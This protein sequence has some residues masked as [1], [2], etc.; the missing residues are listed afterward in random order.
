[1]TDTARTILIVA[2]RTASTPALLTRVRAS[3]RG[4]SFMV[5][6]PPEAADAV[7][8]ST[9]DACRLLGAA[10]GS[11]VTHVSPGEDAAVT[12]HRLVAEGACDEVILST[13]AV[14]HRRWLHHD[15][16]QKLQDLSIPV[17]V[18]PPEAEGWG[19]IAGFPPDWVPGAVSPAGTAGLGNY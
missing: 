10:A 12:V 1:M 14:H 4:T 8:W 11:A 16:P 13:H 2:N 9:E 18:I 3:P 15:L 5:L 6:V 17:T 19:P 7:D